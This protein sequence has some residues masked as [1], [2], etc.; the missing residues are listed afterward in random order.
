MRWLMHKPFLPQ[1]HLEMYLIL[2]KDDYVN[3]LGYTTIEIQV[4]N[5]KRKTEFHVVH[6]SFP[7]PHEGIL[8]K[9]FIVGNEAIIN[10][11]TKELILNN[12]IDVTATNRNSR[13]GTSSEQTTKFKCNSGYAKP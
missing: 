1:H 13:S 11:Q 6:S 8:G 3:T 4:G 5:D 12:S 9:P 7:T 2:M 10:Y